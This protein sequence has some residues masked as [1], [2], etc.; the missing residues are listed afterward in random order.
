MAQE[1]LFV[2]LQVNGYAGTDFNGDDLTAEQLEHA[3]NHLR[4][5]GVET[6]LATVITDEVGAM[7]RRIANIVRLRE[8]SPLAQEMISGLHIEGPFISPREGFVG[9]HPKTAVQPASIEVMQALVEAGNGLV[10][11]VTLAPEYDAKAQVTRWLVDNQ[12]VVSAGHCDP[13]SEELLA[14]IDGGL[15]MFT[16]LGNGCPLN[17]HRHDNVIQRVLAH[18]E[19][20]WICFIVDGV[21]VPYP[22]LRNYL[23]VAGIE[24]S[25]VVSD[26]ISA[27]GMGPGSFLLGGQKVVVDETLATWSADRSHLMGSAMTM[28]QAFRQLRKELSLS[29]ADAIRLTSANPRVAV[30]L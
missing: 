8:S 17:M 7:C 6:I 15:S 24:R 14:A 22:A 18:S 12:M 30:G 5:D 28:P 19:R 26:A 20:L 13:S 29:E 10:R 25:I 9:T 1:N 11:L 21:H 27:A 23:K 4:D 2:D 3:C 16:H